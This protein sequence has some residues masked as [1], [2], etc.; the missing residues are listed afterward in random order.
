MDEMQ[1]AIAQIEAAQADIARIMAERA[2]IYRELADL[3]G[4]LVDRVAD[5]MYG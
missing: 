3:F 2:V 1:A 4:V 5:V